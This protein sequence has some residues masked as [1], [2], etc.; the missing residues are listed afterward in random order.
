MEVNTFALLACLEECCD[1]DRATAEAVLLNGMLG[2]LLD[3]IFFRV[4]TVSSREEPYLLESI[5][6]VCSAIAK[7]TNVTTITKPSG[8]RHLLV[9]SQLVRDHIG[10]N[11]CYPLLR[12]YVNL[13]T[14]EDLPRDLLGYVVVIQNAKRHR[15]D[16]DVNG[17]YLFQRFD[18]L[19]K[20]VF[21]RVYIFGAA[22]EG[23]STPLYIYFFFGRWQISFREDS[24]NH[25]ASC[26]DNADSPELAFEYW[27]YDGEERAMD[28][29]G[30]RD[31]SQLF[32]ADVGISVSSLADAPVQAIIGEWVVGNAL[33]LLL[34]NFF[35]LSPP[36]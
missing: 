28:K 19:G 7:H 13:L 18:G 5:V 9:E 16:V 27:V 36:L 17:V 1:K 29:T 23:N 31:L 22:P 32:P 20:P 8:D 35:H 24:P 25:I 14:G 15:M 30:G 2:T 12:T 26:R 6:K 34:Q 21:K 10:K 4:K 3:R 11:I 33:C